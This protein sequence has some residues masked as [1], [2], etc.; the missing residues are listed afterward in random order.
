MSQLN[1][2][3]NTDNSQVNPISEDNIGQTQTVQKETKLITKILLFLIVFSI[4]AVGTTIIA[5]IYTN[6]SKDKGNVVLPNNTKS[7][8]SKISTVTDD[9]LGIKALTETY[10]ENSLKINNVYDAA[11]PLVQSYYGNSSTQKISIHYITI[12]GLRDKSIETKINNEIHDL[13]Y[14]SFSINDLEND[15]IYNM[16]IETYCTANFGNV[17]SVYVYVST[18]YIDNAH[19][20][21]YYCLN[22]DLTTG[23]HLQFKDLFTNSSLKNA[24]IQPVYD[25]VLSTHYYD[26]EE[27]DD[28]YGYTDQ[29]DL[30]RIDLSMVE[31]E[32]YI[33]VNKILSNIDNITFSF[34]PSDITIFNLNDSPI[35]LR[36]DSIYKSIAI[37][38]RYKTSNS[39]F[40]GTYTGSKN[41]F[42]F[43][44]TRI[45]EDNIL[46]S[47][48]E[49]IYDNCRVDII[50]EKYVSEEILNSYGSQFEDAQRQTINYVEEQ[51]E[52]VST[53]AKNNPDKAYILSIYCSITSGPDYEL[54][55][56]YNIQNE[57][58]HANT[59][60]SIYTTSKQY[61]KDTYYNRIAE[62][63]RNSI[64]IRSVFY[65]YTS[66]DP[67]EK[68]EE[69]TN[70]NVSV[71][72]TNQDIVYYDLYSG[73][74]KEQLL[75]DMQ[76]AQEE[77]LRQQ[78]LL[79][80][81]EEIRRQEEQ[82]VQLEN[83][84]NSDEN[85]NANVIVNTISSDYENNM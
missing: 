7:Q 39:I 20:S 21:K 26:T 57:M 23:N 59:N 45:E 14:N 32:T 4:I 67:N 63:Y 28:K 74:T 81:Q 58:I 46:Y 52:K 34:T 77:A 64:E 31:D 16:Y 13:V 15:D 18:N 49:N 37:Y 22:Y 70:S 55:Y 41:N 62:F 54:K 8:T 35:Y 2:E 5:I 42:V 33:L 12:E 79:Q 48:Y 3:N 1:E 40:D 68:I 10:D 11:G 71:E 82:Q 25:Y 65:D 83:Q 73:K 29:I 47:K 6:N 78:E 19:S 66:M 53:M 9:G 43:A 69:Y 30:N 84:T 36:M 38:N 51:I 85:D 50:V 44:M 80:Q 72:R 24:L 27:D 76:N 75:Q 61:Y 60:S 17:I 56:I